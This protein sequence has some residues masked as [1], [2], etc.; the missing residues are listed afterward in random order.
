MPK[1]PF[2]RRPLIWTASIVVILVAGSSLWSSLQEEHN[3]W[4]STS[5]TVARTVANVPPPKHIEFDV[6]NTAVPQGQIHGG[7]VGVDGIPALTAPKFIMANQASYLKDSDRIIGVVLD[8]HQPKA[9]PLA[10]LNFH[11]IVNDTI[12]DQEIA[13]TYCPLCDSSAVFDRKVNG[14]VREFG[15]SGLLHNSNVLMYDRTEGRE[16]LWSQVKKMAISGTS[17]NQQLAPLPFEVTTW[18]NWQSRHPGSLVLS[19]DTG[20]ERPYNHSP[21]ADYMKSPK[22]MFPAAPSSDR[23]PSKTLVIGVWSADSQRA[24]PLSLFGQNQKEIR[25]SIDG[26]EIVLVLSEDGQSVRVE[27]ANESLSWMYSFWFAWYA[28]YPET[29]V[30]APLTSDAV[31]K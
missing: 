21:Y 31:V 17:V 14:E 18:K 15:V 26:K 27:S 2:F 1:K 30:Y 22:L 4:P 20:H 6:S 28:F 29:T 10:I 8:D 7:G 9:Y 11:E 23:L 24:Y 3:L 16:S 12:G 5:S 19:T 25:D 13:V